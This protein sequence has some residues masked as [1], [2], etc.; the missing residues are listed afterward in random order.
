M[1]PFKFLTKNAHTE[2]DVEYY[3]TDEFEFVDVSPVLYSPETFEP[4]RF[5]LFKNRESGEVIKGNRIR[6]DHPMWNF[7]DIM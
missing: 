1:R 6:T 4:T 2:Y 5:M 7:P 3:H